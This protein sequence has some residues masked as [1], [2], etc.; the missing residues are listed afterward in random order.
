[1]DSDERMEVLVVR[2][3]NALER[4]ATAQEQH[5]ACINKMMNTGIRFPVDV[6]GE[7][8]TKSS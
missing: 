8:R 4:I 5:N 2:M 1:M 3:T 7:L 6:V